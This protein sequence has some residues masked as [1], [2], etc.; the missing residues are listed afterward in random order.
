MHVLFV[1]GSPRK[2]GNSETMAHSAAEV[3]QHNGASV[4]MLRLHGANILPC[5]GCGGC[6][7]N[8]GDCVVRS[9]DMT[10]MYEAVDRADRIVLVSPVY[11]YG[12]TAQAKI[13]IDRFQAYW[14]RKYLH[15]KVTPE[16]SNK[17]G[18]FMGCAATSGKKV[19]DGCLL[20]VK[21]FFDSLDIGYGGS[22]L[23][24]GIDH[25]EAASKDEAILSQ[26]KQFG[27]EI[28]MTDDG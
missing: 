28:V 26:C 11:F 6:E 2:S 14:A 8:D 19:F 7:K 10:K 15:K 20:T 25:P 18:F 4:E 5:T 1:L 9:D 17:K 27:E 24:R 21:C 13:F 16:N 22:L 3:V 12:V 23:I